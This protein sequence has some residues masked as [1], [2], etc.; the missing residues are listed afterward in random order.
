MEV[1]GASA[2]ARRAAVAAAAS[3]KGLEAAEAAAACAGTA[4]GTIAPRGASSE[5]AVA[6]CDIAAGGG[7][8]GA[9]TDAEA[10]EA[11][12]AGSGAPAA[13]AMC[14][15]FMGALG[16]AAAAGAWMLYSWCGCVC[17]SVGLVSSAAAASTDVLCPPTQPHTYT[18][19]T[20][21]R[22]SLPRYVCLPHLGLG[23]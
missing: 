5:N 9:G 19:I 2:M 13:P 22:A 8:G 23:W 12:A 16:G 11:L 15:A 17:T 14:A 7:G 10:V 6:G 21:P 18:G 3:A 1:E 4:A 20:S